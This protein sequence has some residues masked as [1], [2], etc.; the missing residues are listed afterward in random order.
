MRTSRFLG[1]SSLVITA[2][3]LVA[4]G[5]AQK[6]A[7]RLRTASAEATTPKPAGDGKIPITTSSPE[8]K[9]EYEQGRTS[10]TT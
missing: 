4:A 9:A 7:Q 2:F 1:L 8:A 6:D 10:S 5:C 3:G